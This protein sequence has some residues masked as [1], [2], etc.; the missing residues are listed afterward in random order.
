MNALRQLWR[1]FF[2][3]RPN[4]RGRVLF[5]FLNLLFVLF[6]YY[7]LKPVSRALFLTKFDIDKLPWLYILIAAVGGVL[8]FVYTKVAIRSSL[9]KAVLGS[10]I[11]SI[12]CLVILW[13]LLNRPNPGAWLFYLFNIWV[14]LFSIMLVSQGWLVAANVFNSREA[15]RL[16]GVLGVGAVIGA[17]FGGTFTAYATKL[18]GVNN[19]VLAS[20]FMVLMA[21][22]AYVG[23]TRQPGV[24]LDR[25]KGADEEE[26]EFHFKD[27]VAAVVEYR[28]LQ[29]IVGIITI[30]YIVD[31]LVEYQ[32]SAMAK[33]NYQ[34]KE[35][36][37]VFLGSF[38][39]I[40]LNLIT[41]FFQFFLTA[42]VV[43]LFGVGGTLQIMPATITLASIATLA[44]PSVLSTASARLAEAATR[45]TFNRTGMELL[46]LPLPTELKNRTKAFV[47]IFVDRFARGLGGGILILAGLVDLE[48][49]YVSVI[50]MV[51]CIGWMYLSAIARREYISTVRKRLESRR[52]DI[53]SVRVS[54]SD[55]A[56]I[57]LL[58]STARQGNPRQAAYALSLLEASQ[59][60][61]LG[62]LLD[63]LADS[64]HPDVRAKVL[65]LARKSGHAALLDRSLRELRSFRAGEHSPTLA[66]AVAYALTFSPEVARLA[67]T[68]LDHTNDQVQ[69]STVDFLADSPAVAREL[70]A[71]DWFSQCKSS[72]QPH[73]RRLAALAL[74]GFPDTHHA[75]LLPLLRDPDPRVAEAAFRTASVLQDRSYIAP[76]VDRLCESRLRGSALSAL[77]AFGPRIT[78]TLGDLLMD[79]SSSASSRRHIAR[80]LQQIPH[81]R[82]VDVLME[83]IAESDLSVRSA[84]LRALHRLRETAPKL[85][86]GRTSVSDQ[87]LKEARNYYELHAALAPLRQ[88]QDR[89]KATGLLAATLEERLKATIQRL[90]YLLGLKYP[91]REVYAAYLAVN[92]GKAEEVSTAIEFL[93]N[94]LERPHKKLLLPLFD[95]PEHLAERGREEFGLQSLDAERAIRTLLD[96]GEEWLVCCSMAAAAELG[97][98]SLLPRIQELRQGAGLEVGRVADMAVAQ[99]AA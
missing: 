38:F 83:A 81:Q 84:V 24:Q 98:H 77:A 69:E 58:E 65:E 30:T 59:S 2:D 16:Y 73:R 12:A 76:M 34:S 85:N 79:P 52:L 62:P 40:Y 26:A 67:R 42:L 53:E 74:R 43:R 51:S 90:F 50:V 75:D 64:P 4:E 41:F 60:A 33:A 23:L 71:T 3:I 80:A 7:I 63:E 47:D 6:A 14:S 20:A 44:F 1:S 28:H 61:A 17:A 66:P 25:A 39:G 99:L 13:A 72:A 89:H 56:T 86:F 36:M 27:I 70:L 45:Y 9:S 87:I 94:T 91:P 18:F 8:A 57:Q 5:M 95:A 78:G 48:V 93:D 32:F 35:Q 82:S 15:K 29:V 68:L 55:P 96:S 37:T 49:R 19:L 92:R 54:V 22:L 10:T 88:N 21:Y 11:I 31:V 46:Y 97:I